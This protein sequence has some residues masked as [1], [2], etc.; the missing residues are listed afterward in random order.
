MKLT[1]I[2]RF[3]LAL[4]SAFYSC[5]AYSQELSIN[6]NADT[7]VAAG[8]A[9]RL[10]FW[11]VSGKHG[12][13]P[14]SSAGL[15]QAGF[16]LRYTTADS[17]LVETAA[18][19]AGGLIQGGHKGL[20]PYG[21]VDRL[22]LSTGWRMLRMDIGMRPR[23]N[24]LGPLSLTGGNVA[25]TGNARNLPG[26]DL[27][28]DWIWFGR[29]RIFGVRGNIAHY[30]PFD[31]RYVSGMKIH[32]KSLEMKFRIAGC[33]EVSGGLEHIV[34][35]G[36]FSPS[37]GRQPSAFKDFVAVFFA[38][39]GDEDAHPSDQLN[40]LGNHLG[41]EYLRI[42]W[43]HDAFDMTFQ[44]DKPYEDGSS[45]RLQN[46]PDGVWT[47][48]FSMSDRNALITDVL[49]ELASTTW[50][51][52]PVH[53]RPATEE[54]MSKQDPEDPYYGRVVLGGCDS[55]FNNGIYRSGWT[56]Y[57]RVIGLPLIGGVEF[58][59]DGIPVR[60]LNNRVRAHH[61]G[62]AGNISGV[63]YRFKG[64]YSRNYGCYGQ[65]SDSF[66]N[67]VPWQL[68]LGLEA[69][70]SRKVTRLPVDIHI[71]AYSD[72]GQLYPDSY[73]LTFRVSYSGT[74]KSS[75]SR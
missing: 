23:K 56:Y 39:R 13:I 30:Q 51:S 18:D 26:V 37:E 10:P 15:V 67:A 32:D 66:Y 2:Y 73:G 63:P 65:G 60:L 64:T 5:M 50:Q 40:V 47:L 71:G 28:S 59:S 6:W 46:I 17:L 75:R 58:N 70:V 4:M 27:R 20:V 53:D 11:A 12:I 29:S 38:A 22:Y 7:F 52:G 3:V 16:G 45:S 61:V 54:E 35:W 36:G 44:Y 68:S 33:V 43:I 57:G 49:Y 62:V 48:K 24:E 72:L 1:H 14:E 8:S 69:C 41:R 25:W 9:D 74:W 21:I 31:D 42:R 19:F 55:Y 34:Q